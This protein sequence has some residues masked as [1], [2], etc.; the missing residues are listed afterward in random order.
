MKLFQQ[1]RFKHELNSLNRSVR[2][3]TSVTEM[4][5]L[6]CKFHVLKG[7]MLICLSHQNLFLARY[8]AKSHGFFRWVVKFNLT[9]LGVCENSI[10]LFR[11]V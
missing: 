9:I 5:S 7:K 3:A 1:D 4:S 6:K 2:T 10:F 8:N 11:T